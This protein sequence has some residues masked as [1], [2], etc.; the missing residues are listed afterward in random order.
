MNEHHMRY[1]DNPIFINTDEVLAR[2]KRT[3]LFA[4]GIMVQLLGCCGN[5]P[6]QWEPA[7][8]AAW[9]T[10]HGAGDVISEA[11]LREIEDNLHLFF[12]VLPDGRWV[13]SHEVFSVV[14][15]NPG[16]AS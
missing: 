11:D 9:L 15:G 3:S 2:S 6:F 13:P 14:D 4:V 1:A 7:A 5:G 12:F 10:E 16:S 8:I